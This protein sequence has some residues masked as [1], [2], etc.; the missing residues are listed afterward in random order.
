MFKFE[1]LRVYQ[2]SQE[3]TNI[4]YK[5]TSTWPKTE[6]Y[7]L[8]DQ[9]RRATVSISLNIAGGSSRSKR[10]FGHFL[11]IARGSC[12]ECVAIL[13]VAKGLNYVDKNKFDLLYEKYEKMVRMLFALGK[14]LLIVRK[15]DA[16]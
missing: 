12:F 15:S 9:L 5:L 7:G 13:T 2:E 11:N 8:V 6:M 4:I 14:S 16:L 10:D 3:L 1:E